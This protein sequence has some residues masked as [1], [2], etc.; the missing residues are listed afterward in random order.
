MAYELVKQVRDAAPKAIHFFVD[1]A[2]SGKSLL[3][4][5]GQVTHGCCIRMNANGVRE[6][7]TSTADATPWKPASDRR[8]ENKTVRKKKE[9]I[10][11]ASESSSLRTGR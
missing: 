9:K 3:R 1:D 7:F 10:T 11:D 6:I 5:P 8:T 4:M 2:K